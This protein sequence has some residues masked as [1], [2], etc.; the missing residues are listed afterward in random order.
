MKMKHQGKGLTKKAREEREEVASV[1]KF[2]QR[3]P[4]GAALCVPEPLAEDVETFTHSAN[5]K[6]PRSFE[7]INIYRYLK[8]ISSVDKTFLSGGKRI[9]EQT[10]EI[11][12][13]T[14]NEDGENWLHQYEQEEQEKQSH[15]LHEQAESA[16]GLQK[17]IQ[18]YIQQVEQLQQTVVQKFP[19]VRDSSLS[20]LLPELVS[21][22]P[23]FQESIEQALFQ[24]MQE[25]IEQCQEWMEQVTQQLLAQI[26]KE[27]EEHTHQIRK[28]S[29]GVVDIQKQTQQLAQ[30][31]HQ[32]AEITKSVFARQQGMEPK[33]SPSFMNPNQSQSLIPTTPKEMDTALTWPELCRAVLEQIP[34]SEQISLPDLHKKLLQQGIPIRPGALQ[35]V[36]RSLV[37]KGHAFFL[38]W[39]LATYEIPAPHFAILLPRSQII[40]FVKR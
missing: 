38:P 5:G 25:W 20:F 23:R 18:T 35:D 19:S 36:L 24:Q 31:S 3:H 32:L 11:S 6:L 13:Y 10:V 21:W 14:L 9:R 30:N 17:V 34:S 2:F 8:F 22:L 40:Y 28:S 33:N 15:A 26:Q 16:E 1:L 27:W 4:Q 37:E 29:L 12:L 7:K 39:T